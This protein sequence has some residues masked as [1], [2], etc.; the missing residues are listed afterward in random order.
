MY[1]IQ[2]QF[3]PGNSIIWVAKL[4]QNDPVY[5]YD[6][7]N[8]AINQASILQESDTTGRTYRVVLIN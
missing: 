4:N 7:E 1:Q 3:I 8:D 2:F 5:N 6:N